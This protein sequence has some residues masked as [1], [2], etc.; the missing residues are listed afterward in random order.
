MISSNPAATLARTGRPGP[1]SGFT[2]IEMMIAITIG[3]GILAGLVG[4]LA[5]N[6]N[7]SRSNDRTSELMSNGRYALNSMKTELRQAGFR[8]YTW[9]EP[10]TITPS[11]L[12]ALSNECL[13]SGASA[14]A[15]ISNIRQGIWG[16]NN[17]NPFSGSCIP[18]ASFSAGNDVLVVRRV[19]A[20]AATSLSANTVYFQSSYA[21]GQ[22]FRGTTAPVFD[23]SQVP[24][25]SFAV[26]IYVYY[27]SPFSVSASESPLVPAL[28]RVSLQSDG[29]M[30]RELV[31]S[32]IER[33]HVQYGKLIPGL[34]PTTQFFNTLAGSSVTTA[35]T[36]WDNVNVVRIWLLAR[37][38]TAEPGYVNNNVYVLGDASYDYSA[39]PDSFRRQVFSTVVDL[40]N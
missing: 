18:S 4:V 6:S 34:T 5:T 37:N 9:A 32:G 10:T 21:I 12:G 38:E 25:A 35:V 26:Q 36:D 16:A 1:Q 24:V 3:L 19:A 14:G 2:L 31:A 15:F 30:S 8:A 39:A 27:I 20:T 17:S 13:E 23:A 33:M 29:S 7:N 28:Y 40:R 11:T 22:V